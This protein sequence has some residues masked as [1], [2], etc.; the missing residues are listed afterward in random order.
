MNIEHLIQV[1]DR[2]RKGRDLSF[3]KE[4]EEKGRKKPIT[5]K[6]REKGGKKVK[7]LLTLRIEIG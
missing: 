6:K 7:N 2:S 5:E 1:K 4:R 3:L